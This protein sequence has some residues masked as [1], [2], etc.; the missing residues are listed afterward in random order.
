MDNEVGS[1]LQLIADGVGLEDDLTLNRATARLRDGVNSQ[2]ARPQAGIR[3]VRSLKSVEVFNFQTFLKVKFNEV[4]VLGAP[5]CQNAKT[6]IR[7]L[8]TLFI[9]V[10][11]WG[12]SQLSTMVMGCA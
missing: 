7:W 6:F 8:G 10:A 5:L 2:C 3:G 12:Y 1:R 4:Q 11:S 9:K